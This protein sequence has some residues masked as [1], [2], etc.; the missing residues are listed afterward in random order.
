MI[1][2]V[3]LISATKFVLKRPKNPNFEILSTLPLIGHILKFYFF[4]L[5]DFIFSFSYKIIDDSKKIMYA[6]Q[7]KKIVAKIHFLFGLDAIKN[8][9]LADAKMRFWLTSKFIPNSKTLYYHFAL[10]SYLRGDIKQAAQWLIKIR[11]TQKYNTKRVQ[12]LVRCIKKTNYDVLK[13][14]NI[15]L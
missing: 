2:K 7:N 5:T 15:I 6:N 1:K 3:N 11:S 12:D 4:K 14:I 10:L 13:K 8:N 9:K